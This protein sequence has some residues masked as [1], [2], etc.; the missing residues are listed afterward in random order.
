MEQVQHLIGQLQ[1]PELSQTDPANTELIR[2]SS[3]FPIIEQAIYSPNPTIKRLV[4]SILALQVTVPS[5]SEWIVSSRSFLAFKHKQ[6]IY[7]VLPILD[8]VT[9]CG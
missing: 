8:I 6:T 4:Y 5:A 9:F 1:N 3:L 2:D 7:P